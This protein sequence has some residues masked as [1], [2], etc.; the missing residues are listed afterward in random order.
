MYVWIENQLREFFTY[1]QRFFLI[2]GGR[3]LGKTYSLQKILV[4]SALRRKKEICYVVRNKDE[5]DAGIVY[6]AFEKVFRNEFPDYEFVSKGDTVYLREGKVLTKLIRGMALRKAQDYKKHAYPLIDYMLFDEYMIEK[7]TPM[8]YISGYKEPKLLLSIYDTIDRGED[9]V[10]CFLLGNTTVYY[11]PYH[12]WDTFAPLFRTQAKKGEIKKIANAVFW[13]AE[14]PEDVKELRRQ[15]AFAQMTEGTD[16]GNFALE[17]EYEDDITAIEPMPSGAKCLFAL[18]YNDIII[19]VFKGTAETSCYWLSSAR[20]TS[21]P[22]YAVRG[23]DVKQGIPSFKTS[24][25]YL[26]FE[27]MWNSGKVFFA[28]QKSKTMAQEFLWYILSSYRKV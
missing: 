19:S 11:N 9:R 3:D 21:K 23:N 6:D 16:Y 17:G 7:D 15:T 18:A 1:M 22:V 27:F 8:T 10:R 14:P 2:N 13:R 4:E 26:M 28:N 12:I 5:L 20:D 24:A 25:Y